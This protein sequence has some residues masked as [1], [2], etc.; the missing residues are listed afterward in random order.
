MCP[1]PVVAAKSPPTLCAVM[2]PPLV[3][4]RSAPVVLPVTMFPPS[5]VSDAWPF[6]SISWMFPP[7]VVTSTLPSSESTAKAP[8]NPPLVLDGFCAVT[9]IE[10]HRWQV[11]S[12]HWGAIHLGRIYLFASEE[13][14][15]SFLTNPDRYSPVLSGNDPVMRLDHNQDVLGKREYGAFYDDRVYLFASEEN[16][17]R[18]RGDPARYTIDNRQAL[19]R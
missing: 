6:K 18:F 16:F 10:K 11:G 14:R 1:P 19:R 17:Q 9:L 15:K 7:P 13:A 8:G 12:K 3:T 4:T 5:V 2:W